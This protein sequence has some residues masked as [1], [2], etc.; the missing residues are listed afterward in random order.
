MLVFLPKKG[1]CQFFPNLKYYFPYFSCL[2]YYY[3]YVK[4]LRCF[5]KHRS[6]IYSHPN[7]LLL[8]FPNPGSCL[9]VS[10]PILQTVLSNLASLHISILFFYINY[11]SIVYFLISFPCFIFTRTKI[12]FLLTTTLCQSLAFLIQFSIVICF[13]LLYAYIP[14]H[15][16]HS[17]YNSNFQ[18]FKNYNCTIFFLLF[19]KNHTFS[20]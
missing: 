8:C 20:G 15:I 14:F 10:G 3:I 1:I 2:D 16:T 6:L 17:N 18:V 9:Q 13:I 12:L 4:S 5:P 11:C 19:L 7:L